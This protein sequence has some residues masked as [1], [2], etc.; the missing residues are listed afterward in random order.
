M[1]KDIEDVNTYELTINELYDKIFSLILE[2]EIDSTKKYIWY[3]NHWYPFT[4]DH[5]LIC[6]V[7]GLIDY[8]CD[9]MKGILN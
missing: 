8:Y 3:N 4:E 6:P 5:D 2:Q 7:E 9:V 1:K